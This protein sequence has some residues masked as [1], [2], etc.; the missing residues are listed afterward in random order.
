MSLKITVGFSPTYGNRVLEY[1][2]VRPAI[3]FVCNYLITFHEVSSSVAF[4]FPTTSARL[5]GQGCYWL[6]LH[7]RM[8]V[9]RLS[10]SEVCFL[11]NEFCCKLLSIGASNATGFRRL[12]SCD[13]RM[14]SLPAA[15]VQPKCLLIYWTLNMWLSPISTLANIG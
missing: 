12:V 1:S 15:G 7:I 8:A 13:R 4:E 5:D 6:R 14:Q 9:M 2:R 11:H 10:N 3:F